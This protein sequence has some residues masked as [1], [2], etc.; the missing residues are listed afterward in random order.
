MRVAAELARAAAASVASISGSGQP[1]PLAPRLFCAAVGRSVKSHGA[2][3]PNHHR[4]AFSLKAA[5]DEP[6][7]GGVGST[8][9]VRGR[10]L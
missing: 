8:H 4:I 10:L 5:S 2:R 7:S 3:P 6:I 9:T 1:L